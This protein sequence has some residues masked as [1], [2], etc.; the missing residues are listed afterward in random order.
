MRVQEPQSLRAIAFKKPPLFPTRS[1]WVI[2]E[3]RTDITRTTKSV[4]YPTLGPRIMAKTLR[5]AGST[6][7]PPL[8][9]TRDI[10][11][12]ASSK[13]SYGGSITVDILTVNVQRKIAKVVF[14]VW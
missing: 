11:N 9:R 12:L 6:P 4:F 14:G 2:F 1:M 8:L 5:R 7:E 13:S 3:E 10:G